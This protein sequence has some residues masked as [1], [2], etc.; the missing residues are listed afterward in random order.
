M[1][2]WKVEKYQKRHL[3]RMDLSMLK[4]MMMAQRPLVRIDS[5]RCIKN[6]RTNGDEN[7][8]HLQDGYGRY[9]V[10]EMGDRVSIRGTGNCQSLEYYGVDLQNMWA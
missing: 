10:L 1:T 9:F 6:H 8:T 3:G 7:P 4:S 2:G 5:I